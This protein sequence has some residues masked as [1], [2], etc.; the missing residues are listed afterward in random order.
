VTSCCR[1]SPPLL[2]LLLLLLQGQYRKAHELKVAAD[3]MYA[4]ELAA[5]QAGWDSEVAL[6]KTRLLAK[7]QGE[8]RTSSNIMLRCGACVVPESVSKQLRCGRVW[9]SRWP[10]MTVR[11]G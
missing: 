1:H 6:R 5:T 8:H 10:G 4:E 9:W 11:S 7:Q 2:L 3:A